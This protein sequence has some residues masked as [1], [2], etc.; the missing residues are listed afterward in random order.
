[1]RRDLYEK[2]VQYI[3]ENQDK[4]YRLA[5]SYVRNQD[6]ALDAVQNAVCKAL[7]HYEGLKDAGAIRTWMYR[8]V[9]NESL[10]ILKERKKEGPAV[11][12]E[13]QEIPWEEKA[14]EGQDGLWNEIS[15]LPEDVQTI[16]KLRFYEELPL[17][18]IARVMEMNLN[19]VK[20]KLYRGLRTLRVMLETS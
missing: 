5:Y 14:Y 17:K 16:V 8:I 1:M 15:Q 7:E 12:E 20:G 13:Q 6:D 4:F 19:T 10:M 9:V 18:E 3:I 2:I 11:L